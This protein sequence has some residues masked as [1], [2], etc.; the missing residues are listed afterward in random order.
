MLRKILIFL[1]VLV[2]GVLLFAAT[3]PDKFV[4]QRSTTINAPADKIFPLINDFRAWTKWS[5]YEHRDPNLKRTLSGA[6]Q[7]K[8][9]IY[10]WAGDAN[11]GKGRMEILEAAPPSKV[12]IKLDF[13]EPFEGHN[14]AEFTLAG[15]GNGTAVTWSMFGPNTFGSNLMSVFM[16][17]DT[18]I[19]GDFEA[20]LANLK[21]VAEQ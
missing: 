18:M 8:G 16:N 12:T 17:F 10:E 13:I 9:A 15:G 19:G 2:V 5:P 14:M 11:V 7:G 1:V 4:V 3:K 6:P 20:G 21:R